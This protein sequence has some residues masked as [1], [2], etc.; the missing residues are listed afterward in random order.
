MVTSPLRTF[1]AS[2]RTP[3]SIEL[4]QAAFTVAFTVSRSPTSTG[5]RKVIRSMAAVTTRRPEWRTAAI[6]ATS[7][8]RC[9]ITPPCTLPAM[10][11][12]AIP[13][14]G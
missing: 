7:S 14:S 5:C 8:Q 6:P 9:R 10:F 13:S 3:T 4:R 12:S 2:T 1:S 11:A